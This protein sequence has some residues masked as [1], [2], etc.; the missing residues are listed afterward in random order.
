MDRRIQLE[1]LSVSQDSNYGGVQQSWTLIATVWAK[2]VPISGREF[3]ASDQLV[4]D[5]MIRFRLRYR[6][7]LDATCRIVYNAKPYNIRYIA[8][9]GRHDEL[10]ITALVVNP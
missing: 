1:R 7:D 9:I 6:S 10:E 4:A 3:F 5:A 8:E 2:L